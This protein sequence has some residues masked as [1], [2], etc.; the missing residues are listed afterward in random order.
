MSKTGKTEIA[1]KR[2]TAAGERR[3]VYAERVGDR[4]Q[5]YIREERFEQWQPMPN[6]PLEDWQELLDGVERRV[7]R[8][9]LRPEEAERI[10]RTIAEKFPEPGEEI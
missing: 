9:L 4:W 3:Q 7:A 1:W 5:F 6:P 8:R 2:K 10:R